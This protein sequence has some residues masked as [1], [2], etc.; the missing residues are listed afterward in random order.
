MGP[1]LRNTP[2]RSLHPAPRAAA[3]GQTLQGE[4]PSEVSSAA[5]RGPGGCAA[6]RWRRPV[7]D[8]GSGGSTAPGP[9]R[10]RPPV[11]GQTERQTL[12][13]IWSKKVT[14]HSNRA[15]ARPLRGSR[16]PEP[17]QR[18]ART[19][20]SPHAD[21]RGGSSHAPWG[22]RRPRGPQGLR[23]APSSGRPGESVQETK[24]STFK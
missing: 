21:K 18:P 11:R 6:G 13:Q 22:H 19:P 24:G 14:K 17:L 5:G 23:A 12:G 2:P 8:T 9:G 7:L 4:R 15:G 3:A 16:D 20:S 1:H 10:L